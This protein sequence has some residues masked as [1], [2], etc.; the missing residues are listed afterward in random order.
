MSSSSCSSSNYLE[1]QWLSH[2]RRYNELKQ[3]F[4]RSCQS[5]TTIDDP[6]ER[7]EL[8]KNAK[9]KMHQIEDLLE[10]MKN[11]LRTM[12]IKH[13]SS[14]SL[15][16]RE[17][18]NFSKQYANLKMEYRKSANKNRFLSM[19][20]STKYERE[21]LLNNNDKYDHIKQKSMES[22]RMLN[23]AEMI[24]INASNNLHSQG[25]QLNQVHTQINQI[26]DISDRAQTIIKTMKTKIYTDRLLQ[27]L[28]VT[29][30]LIIIIFL[31]W[32]KF[33]KDL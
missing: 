10:K 6:F 14:K 2:Q 15:F 17:Y 24:G 31:L 4:H 1:I 25:Q 18:H 28:I 22:L 26:N 7:N 29:V 11:D 3:S 21:R 9:Q 20:S 23:E 5:I 32:W 27:V 12:P 13:K 8:I 19:E 33:R 30:E 16:Q